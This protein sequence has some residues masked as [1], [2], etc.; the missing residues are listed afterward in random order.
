MRILFTG[1]SSGGHVSPIVAVARQLKKTHTIHQSNSQNSSFAKKRVLFKRNDGP[2][3]MY[4]LG[5][6]GFSEDFLRGEGVYV[7]PIFA[8]KLRRYFSFQNFTDIFKLFLGFCQA[9]WYLLIWMPDVVFSKGGGDS[10]PV[11]LT[12]WLYRIPILVHGSDVLPGLANRIASKFSTR[13]AISFNDTKQYFSIK[14]TALV[15]NPVRSDL[16]EKCLAKDPMY[17]K[18]ARTTFRFNDQKPVILILGG[19]RG[20]QQINEVVLNTLPDLLPKY[21][22][23]HQCGANNLQTIKDFLGKTSLL[24]YYL[25]PFLNEKEITAAYLLADLVISRAGATSIFEIAACGKPSILIPLLGH[26]KENAFAYARSGATT[27]MT[28]DNLT[29]H[30]FIDQVNKV[31]EYP[32]FAQTLSQSAKQ[33][34][35]PEAAQ[36]VAQSLIEMG[37]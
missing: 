5:A 1:G 33:F 37:W 25:T 36:I 17:I 27:V 23:I 3:S 16:I 6:G 19:S 10:V 14:K 15:G 11:V 7:K 24:D 26:Q 2:L 34:S 20:A 32:E 9:L 4:Y 29:R 13:T 12:A 22:I 18:E 35:R 8:G 28:Q 21:A 30:V 31:F